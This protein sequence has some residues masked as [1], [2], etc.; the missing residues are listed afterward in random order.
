MEFKNGSDRT[1]SLYWYHD[2]QP[3]P[4]FQGSAWAGAG[5]TINTFHGHTFFWAEEG[6][7]KPLPGGKITIDIGKKKYE[8][9][10]NKDGTINKV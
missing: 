6:S 4:V 2:S 7:D 9:N 10:I 5:F 1:L 3:D 8:Y